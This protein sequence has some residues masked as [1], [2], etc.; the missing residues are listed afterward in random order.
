MTFNSKSICT[1]VATKLGVLAVSFACIFSASAQTTLAQSPMLTLKTAPGLVMLT[2]GRDLPLYRAAYNDVNDLDGDGVPDIFF[3]PAFKYE[4]YFAYDRCY[5][6]DNNVFTPDSYG[7]AVVVDANDTSKNYYKCAGKW[8]GNFLNWVTMARIDV[9]RKVLYGGKRSTDDAD[10]VLERTYVP[11]DSTLWGK[12][13]ASPARDGYKI[14]EYTPLA[15]PTGT[16][17][18]NKHFFVNVTLQGTTATFATTVEAPKMIVYQ[19]Q[20]GRIWDLV[21][22]EQLILGT[23]PTGTGIAQHIVRV[24]TCVLLPLKAPATGSK[25]EDMCTGYP[26][27][28][29]TSYKPTGLLH[30]Y[31]ESKQLA[32][33]LLSG[34]YDNN[35]AG[36]V[37]RQN[38]D[39]FSREVNPAN[40]RY[41][42]KTGTPSGIIHHLDAFRPWGFG[43]GTW[44]GEDYTKWNFNQVPGNGA[45]SMWGNPLG[46]MMLES[47]RYFSGL[48]PSTAFTSGV[49][50]NGALVTGSGAPNYLIPRVPARTSPEGPLQ[51]TTASWLNPY[52]ASNARTNSAAYP[53][54]SRPIQMT[55]GDPKTSFDSDHFP[56]SSFS[57]DSNKGANTVPALSGLNVSNEAD[58]IWNAEFSGSRKFFVG[59]APGNVDGNPSAKVASSF[60]NIR[61]HGPDATQSQ[62]SFYGASVAR[63]GKYTGVKNPALPAS[64]PLRVEQ[65]SIALDSH[66]PKIQIPM[67][68]GKSISLVLMSKSISDYG[69]TTDRTKYQGTGQITA[70][71]IDKMANTNATNVDATVNSGYPYYKFRVSFSDMDQGGDNESD[72]KVTYEIKVNGPAATAT[73]LSIGMEYMQSSTGIEI[74]QGYV[75]SGSTNDGLYLDV[76]GAN[77]FGTPPPATKLGYYLDTMPGKSPGSAMTDLGPTGGIPTGPAY[78]NITSRLPLSTLDVPATNTTAAIKKARV[79]NVG[80][81]TNGEYV[82]HDMLWYAAKYGS[83]SQD[84]N[85]TFTG[86][87]LK[88]NGDPEN[89][90]FANNPSALASQIG[91]AFQKAANLSIA[92]ASAVASS[93][94]KV[95][96]GN[97]VYQVSFDSNN[98]GGEVRA[99][100]VKA[101][102]NIE[103]TPTWVATDKQPVP[104]AR[105]VVL[106]MATSASPTLKSTSLNASSFSS[107]TGG[108]TI[109]KDDATFRYLL[110][111][112]TNEQGAVGGT[113]KF[114]IRTSAIGDI[115]NSDPLY[116]GKYD[117]GYTDAGYDTFKAASEPKLLGVGSNDGFYRLLS[118]TTGVEQLAFIP[119]TIST[120]M[121]KLADP[122]YT[123]QYFVDGSSAWGHVNFGVVTP[124]W[125]AVVAGSLG[126]GGKAV[127]ALNASATDLNTTN[128]GVLWE[129]V[130][131][132]NSSAGDYLGY[133]LNKPIV[134]QLSGASGKPAVIVGNGINST[135]NKASLLVLNAQTGVVIANCTPLDAANALGNGMTSVTPVSVAKNGKVDFV[136]AGDYM[137]N[138]WRIDP[139]LGS[140]NCDSV[141]VFTAKDGSGKVQ[142]ITGD[143]TVT[144]APGTKTGYMILFGTGKFSS[145]E[146]PANTDVQTMYGVWDAY[147]TSPIATKDALR[148]DL[149]PYA[150]GT[151]DTT[152]KTRKLAAKAAT[153]NA[154]YDQTGNK[155]GWLVDLT[156]SGCPAG[157][158]FLDKPLIAG[159]A[160]NPIV[161]FLTYIPGADVCNVGGDGWVTGLN[162]ATGA[163]SKAYTSIDDNSVFVKGAAPRGLFIVTTA[164]TSTKDAAEY[165]YVSRNGE[166][167]SDD[168]PAAGTNKPG[169]NDVGGA[170]QCVG[171]DC[172]SAGGKEITPPTPPTPTLG[173][174]LVWR[175]IQ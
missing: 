94:V 93:G 130:G 63:F 13:Y 117:F 25:Y 92:T 132:N 87:K 170:E 50:T 154:W 88:P 163:Y 47:V 34:T 58:A 33:G 2:M 62:G 79:F 171:V 166:N 81:S 118:A 40:G 136:Y 103:N 28:N 74:H 19:N 44:G 71:F 139:N 73:S 39:D 134:A 128:N 56:G 21:A 122:A 99:A 175:Q 42:L 107:I 129:F 135:N 133:V 52:A 89:Y 59:E 131:T 159:A 108:A 14:T 23:N 105:N 149:V 48:T 7:T 156:C 3:K 148:G 151:Y 164:K 109:F 51:L 22:A 83:V 57:I 127:F 5:T 70:F 38:I 158:R 20:T 137:G 46:E 165:I 97:L 123:H 113:G 91:Q 11:Q 55:I 86:F 144:A 85:G 8:S 172:I 82:P 84:K 114:R 140:G 29:P 67:A 41:L 98:W 80:T 116:I 162:P 155:K 75:I 145:A 10:T 106:G 121:V 100:A 174:R 120:E 26:T 37:L 64:T 69:L 17:G 104:T 6:S 60:K 153:D 102:G 15:E 125:N 111:D 77:E 68:N 124:N 27:K 54:C 119:K 12:E 152:S 146:D 169:L 147:T 78:T 101:D 66:I 32:F 126:A 76:G 61:G 160:T 24:K 16:V 168:P 31:G 143:L 173:R 150:F 96:G 142:P 45:N 4:G 110:G 18:V 35:Y 53:Q 36:G 9:L 72:A 65:I 112:R 141:K 1:N 115:V 90:Y 49:G 95:S 138:I 167:T 43:K 157:E 161:Y 30:K